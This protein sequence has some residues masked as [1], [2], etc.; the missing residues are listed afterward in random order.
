MTCWG[1]VLCRSPV[2]LYFGTFC[3]KVPTR[4]GAITATTYIRPYKQ[5]AGLSA[6]QT[7]EERFAYG[8]D[9]QKL[10]AVSSHLCDPATAAAEFLLVKSE[11]QAATAR[12]VE[13][14]ALFFQIR[15]AFPPGEV[16]AEEANKLGFETAMRWTKGK[17]Q[18]FVCTHT[19]KGHIHNHIY[20]N[21][22][23]F[24]CSR[25]FHNFLG[26][27][28][29]L[30][31]LSDRVCLEHDLSVIQNPKQHSKGRFL[32]YG[33][34]IGEKPP[35]AQQRVRLAIIAALEK[36]PA[37]FAAFLRLM[38]ESGFAVK[39]GRGGVVSFLAPGQ[40]KYTR[41]RASTLGTGFDP[42]DI[43]AVIA[44]ERPLPELP[45]DAPPPARQVG[46]I[47]DIQKRMAEGKGP[48]YERW[49][50]VYNLKQMAAAL[51]FLQ[52]N[53][54]TDY[55]ALAAKT[56]AAVDRA[57]ALAGELQTTEASLSKVSGLMGAVVDYAKARPAMN[58]LLGGEKLPKMD[59]LKKQRRELADKKKSLYAEYRRAQRDMR[60]AVAVKANIDHLL[61]LTDGRTDKEQT[62]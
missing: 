44:G 60:E 12:P 7:M 21:S 53:N 52:E 8:L 4:G 6:V 18:F 13:R 29:A 51:Q 49:A 37:D 46:L 39:R 1:A 43:R 9:P 11:Y 25:K 22:T 62:R 15:Q 10:G 59:A 17:Y 55:D 24:D 45:K 42:E 50:K 3:P 5:A 27:S 35:S 48:A 40:D 23:A 36:K 47:I 34:W 20:F 61:G 32:H 57:H 33:Q 58:E 19:D 30:R 41:L 14:G 28:F 16:T 31:R 2:F 54:L 26:S 56:T 38:E